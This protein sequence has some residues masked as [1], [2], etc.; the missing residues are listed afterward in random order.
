MMC[1][2]DDD[3]FRIRDELNRLQHRTLHETGIDADSLPSTV[4]NCI[5]MKPFKRS[6]PTRNRRRRTSSKMS[7]STVSNAEL[8][9]AG[10][11]ALIG[12]MDDVIED[13]QDDGLDVVMSSLC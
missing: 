1:I 3:I 11:L 12:G 4:I 13:A 10:N 9:K 6:F 5:R 7:W 8:D 2:E